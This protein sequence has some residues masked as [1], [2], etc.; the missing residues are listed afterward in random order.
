MGKNSATC[1]ELTAVYLVEI[2]FV[3]R[4]VVKNH[5][6]LF[7]TLVDFLY[8]GKIDHAIIPFYQYEIAC[9]ES[10]DAWNHGCHLLFPCQTAVVTE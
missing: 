7:S 1:E 3:L 5:D 9:L 4:L 10:E 8:L 2:S 6:A